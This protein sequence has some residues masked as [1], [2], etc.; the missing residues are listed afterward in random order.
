MNST[1]TNTQESHRNDLQ[2]FIGKNH[3]S[4]ITEAMKGEERDFFTDKILDIYD[5]IKNMPKTYEQDGI[6]DPLVSLHYLLGDMDFYITEKD[7]DSD[8]EGQIQAFGYSDIGYGPE[9]GY[10]SIKE[11]IENGV[12]LDLYFTPCKVSGIPKLAELSNKV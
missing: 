3:M 12:E 10:I 8:G 2:H 11:I 6:L 5:L 9:I 7:I 1:L 4:A